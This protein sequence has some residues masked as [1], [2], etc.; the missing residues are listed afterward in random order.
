MKKVFAVI[1]DVVYNHLGPEGNYLS[2]FAPYFT[3]KYKTPWGSAINFDDE[4]CYGVRQYFIEN[5]LM[6]FRDL[7]VDALRLDAVHAIKDFS[8]THILQE[9]KFM[10]MN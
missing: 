6:W 2:A 9:M 5:V 10:L 8:S 3:E 1:V 4:Y 7:H